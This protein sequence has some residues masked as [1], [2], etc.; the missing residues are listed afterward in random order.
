MSGPFES[1]ERALLV[2]PKGRR[3]LIRLEPGLTFHFHGG[4]VPHDLVLG[5][6]EGTTIRATTGMPLLCFR[7]R[8]ADFTVKMGRGAQVMYPKDLGAVLVYGDV[9]P[10][11]VVLEAGSGSG[12]LTIALSRAVGPDGRVVS[13]EERSEFHARARENVE[14]FFGK[15]P[16]WLDLRHG[17][18]QEAGDSGE[19][20]DRV[21]LDL[22]GPELVLREVG[23]VLRAGGVLCSFL[24]TTGQIQLLTASLERA[25][26]AEIETFELMLRT[27]HV[28]P[29]SVRPNHR[30]VA[31]T[32]FITVARQTTDVD[33]SSRDRPGRYEVT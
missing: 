19:E 22:P 18:I 5:A 8:L 24:P 6:T 10:G 21:L 9:F 20:F 26:F 17:S 14:A 7:P 1:G 25:G 13:Y 27:W 15:A 28:T 2:D 33:R 4:Q 32:G 30:M 29:R 23:A 31:H 3:F 16:A 11:A 12:A